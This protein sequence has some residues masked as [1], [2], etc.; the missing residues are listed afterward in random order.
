[1]NERK[2]KRWIVKNLPLS[3]LPPRYL[4]PSHFPLSCNISQCVTEVQIEN[5]LMN[6]YLLQAAK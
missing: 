1:M 2:K 4:S 3:S 5:P 6:Q